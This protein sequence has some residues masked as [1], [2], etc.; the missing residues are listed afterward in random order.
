MSLTRL[1]QQLT[2]QTSPLSGEQ[3]AHL[4]NLAVGLNPIQQAWLSGYLA[5]SANAQVDAVPAPASTAQPA[6][7]LSIL[8]GSQTG[9]SKAVAQQIKQESDKR[10]IHAKVINM[11]DYKPNQLKKETHIIVAVSTYGEGEPPEDAEVLFEFLGSKKAPA[12]KNLKVAVI[13]LGDS[14]YEY[15]CQTAID[16]EQRFNQLG[17]KT[18]FAR[19]GL[20]VDYQQEANDWINSALDV[21]AEDFDKHHQD[22]AQHFAQ[23]IPLNGFQADSESQ[24]TKTNPLIAEIT[25]VQKITGR[26]SSKDVRHVEIELGDSGL[27]YQPGDALGVYFTN[28]STAV[29]LIL[30][31]LQLSGEE[32][33]QIDDEKSSLKHALTEKLELTQSYPRF[34]EQF[35]QLSNNK[36]L[37]AISTDKAALREYLA[38]RQIIDVI[39]QNAADVGAQAFVDCLRKIQPR[40]YSIASSQAEVESEVHL[41]V[42]VVEYEAF[43]RAHLGGCS[44]YL[45]H[46]T[47]EGAEVRVYVEPNDKFRLPADDNLPIIMVGPGTGIAPFR[48]FLQ[49]RESRG[50]QGKNWLVFGERT[51][52]QDFLYQTEIQAYVKSGL[53]SKIDLAFSRDQADK[54]YVQ[55]RLKLRGAEIYEWL[56]QGAHFYVCGDANHMAKDVHTALKALIQE[57]GVLSDEQAQQ[58]LQDLR[59]DGRYQKDVY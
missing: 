21:F 27:S 44:G 1:T 39:E 45:A 59:S 24:Y 32:Q 49:E 22:S 26:G 5:A 15:F 2:E 52:S 51:F 25:T 55:D 10:G 11:A 56:Q 6:A 30:E 43:G 17:A 16:F 28:D 29:A 18:V 57:H 23:V 31:R 20:N 3:I 42:A 40:L 12:L 4:K 34:V 47:V 50:A 36:E 35:A 46:H 53:L 41:T 33:V 58:Y 13:G 19:A 9:N 8:Y 38:T 7:C 37:I 54:I 48:A 14:S